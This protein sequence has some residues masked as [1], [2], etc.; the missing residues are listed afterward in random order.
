MG[1]LV[2][3]SNRV[4]DLTRSMQSGGLAVGITDALKN[5]GGLWFG[6]NGEISQAGDDAAPTVV[7]AGNVSMA[8]IPLTEAD[9][10]NYYLGFSNSVLWPLF[11]YRLDL[12]DF[13]SRFL[14]GY[15]L[16]NRRF[17]Q[18]LLPLLRDDDTIWVHD[19]HLIPLASELRRLGCRQ[20][21][22]FFLHVP[23]PPPEILAAAPGHKWLADS[24]L[25]YDL[26]GFQ[27]QTDVSNLAR[28]AEDHLQMSPPKAGRMTGP[29]GD[30]HLDAFPIGIDAQAFAQLAASPSDDVQIDSMRRETLGR[31]QIIGVDRLDYSKGLPDRM[32]AFGR[33]LELHP[34]HMKKVT[35]LQIAP[36]TRENVNAYA[37]IRSE[38]EHLSGSIN[39]QFADFNWTPIRYIHRSVPREILAGLYRVS[40]AGLVTPLRDGMNLV[41][42]EFVAAQNPDDPG[43][44]I[45]SKFAGAAEEL[46]EALIVNPYDIDAM[47][48]AIDNALTMPLE[49]RKERHAALFERVSRRDAIAWQQAFLNALEQRSSDARMNVA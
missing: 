26:V 22:G 32:K 21:I 4:A 31:K 43:V 19:Y 7:E 9:Y 40:R 14:D 45:L 1:R 23:F 24:L 41:A 13:H 25:A 42:K 18:A 28:Y 16:V 3:V 38:L 12:V 29:A 17:A 36:P 33:L 47:A 10:A 11:H 2:V 8:T 30:L 39:G 44:L 6:W 46:V 49:E 15:R 34:D 5:R 35:F 37:D 27:T 48:R 20:R